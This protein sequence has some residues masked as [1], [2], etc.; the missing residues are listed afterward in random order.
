MKYHFKACKKFL[1]ILTI[2]LI[3]SVVTSISAAESTDKIILPFG[4]RHYDIGTS[5][6]FV[7]PDTDGD[8][9]DFK[10]TRGHW[11]F[12]HFWASWC[13]P[14]RKEMPTIKTLADELQD[15]IF[16][17]LMINTAEDE[18]TIFTFLAE[19]NIELNS[20]M[21]VDGQVTEIW[22]PRGLPTTFL[23]N[24]QGEVKY[25]AIGGREWNK[26]E[27]IGFLKKLILST[28]ERR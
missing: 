26:P 9:F 20:L 16:Q 17:I 1:F 18:D 24:P 7:L 3:T 23:I 15:E 19:M 4:I 12:L 28:D 22:K 10:S 25:Q 14:C 11:V 21:D 13:G 8:S 27:Y 2:C 5:A 6:N